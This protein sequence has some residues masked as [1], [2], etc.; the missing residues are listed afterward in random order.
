MLVERMKK[1]KRT[2][3]KLEEE[4]GDRGE[5]EDLKGKGNKRIGI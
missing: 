4:K 1:K 2:I 5:E 3:T